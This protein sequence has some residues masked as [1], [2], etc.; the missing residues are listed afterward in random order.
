MRKKLPEDKIDI[1]DE[2]S[3]KGIT[4]GNKNI[5]KSIIFVIGLLAAIIPILEIIFGPLTPMFQRPIHLFLMIGLT[6]FLYPSGFFKNEK[7]E[8][9]LNIILVALLAFVC[10]WASYRWTYFYMTPSP[11]PIEALFGLIFVILVFEATR[12]AIGIA[13]AIIGSIFLIYCFVGP[14]MPRFFAHQGYKPTELV[15]HLIVGV[16]GMMGELA[17]I[18]ANQIV[19]FMMFAAFLRY[20][21]S[22]EIFMDFS[23]AIAGD[24]IG[25]PA[26]VAVVS[27]GF[28]AMVSGSASGNTATTGAVTI[29]LMISLG[30]K[31]HVAGAIEA[32]SS[33]AGQFMPP[34]MGAAAFV[35]AEYTGLSYWD[36]AIAAFLPSLIY[37]II[38]FFVVDMMA[39]KDNISGLPKDQLPP[40]GPSFRKT[41]P[42][43]VPIIILV[44][45]LALRMSVQ[46]SIVVSLIALILI[47]IPIKSQRIGVVQI[48]KALAL[49]AK[50]LIPITTSCAVAG[51]IVGVMS[52]TGFGERLSYGILAFAD[53]NLFR[54]LLLTAIVCLILG[55]GLPTLGAYVV[56][57]TLGAPALQTLGAPILASHLF[58]FYFAIISAI[59][60][61]VCLSSY[62]GASIAGANPMRVGVTSLTLAP[63]IYVLPFLFVFNPAILFQGNIGLVALATVKTLIILFNVTLLFQGYLFARTK[64]YEYI[65]ILVNLIFF[66]YSGNFLIFLVVF[67]GF[68]LLHGIRTGKFI[69][70]KNV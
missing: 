20:T 3:F 62:V 26:K 32:V 68:V 61:P 44:I 60:P 23:K 39:K 70:R 25:G 31:R 27:S 35:I 64:I 7:A 12:R 37:F 36:V 58:I 6:F 34:I 41:I 28:M 10:C 45:M 14:Y 30:F 16:E 17:A 69:K 33:T 4:I 1:F 53:G 46:L 5:I 13:M 18:S 47:C 55:M 59:T 48:F 19:F 56:L 40:I 43:L 29:P 67:A 66:V 51:L 52:L 49:T 15:T 24:K 22:T 63:F 8:S 54:G 57:A 2:N 65:I 21:H 11:L 9:I 38:M 42:I 50:I